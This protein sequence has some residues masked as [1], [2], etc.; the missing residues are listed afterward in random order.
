[1]LAHL[2]F[3]VAYSLTPQPVAHIVKP[4][5]HTVV[6][7]VRQDDVYKLQLRTELCKAKPWI[8]CDP[9]IYQ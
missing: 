1:M 3:A 9:R 5:V 2:L 4:V 7:P 6:H 8:F